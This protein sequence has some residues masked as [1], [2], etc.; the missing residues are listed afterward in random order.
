[1][2]DCNVIVFMR[3]KQEYALDMI[4]LSNGLKLQKGDELLCTREISYGEQSIEPGELIEVNLILYETERQK[5][6]IQV[7]HEFFDSLDLGLNS[8]SGVDTHISSGKLRKV[9]LK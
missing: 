6:S 1:M 9:N 7:N 5:V 4:S 8:E 3:Q 2:F